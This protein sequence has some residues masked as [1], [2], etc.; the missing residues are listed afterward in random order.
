MLAALLV[1]VGAGFV[2]HRLYRFGL[3]HRAAA[4]GKAVWIK[5]HS[6][7]T[8][9]KNQV[10]QL[11]RRSYF[12]MSF[13]HHT[14]TPLMWA[15]H[16]GRRSAAS[17][18][19]DA[20]AAVDQ[21]DSLGRTALWIACEQRRPE[22]VQLLLERGAAPSVQDWRG[23][24]LLWVVIESMN[25]N[26]APSMD[27]LSQLLRAGAD[28]NDAGAADAPPL[29]AAV[30]NDLAEAVRL[31]LRYGAK[32]N[33]L[34]LEGRPLAELLP[35]PVE[36]IPAAQ[37]TSDVVAVSTSG[38]TELRAE[39]GAASMVLTSINRSKGA[40]MH[41]LRSELRL[42]RCAVGD[43]G[44]IVMLGI[45]TPSRSS[46]I[47][48][49][50]SHPDRGMLIDE[51]WADPPHGTGSIVNCD[52]SRRFPAI[53]PET[54]SIVI[55]KSLRCRAQ[56]NQRVDSFVRR[57]SIE[58]GRLLSESELFDGAGGV[59]GRIV[60]SA[61][62][63]G[64]DLIQV[65]LWPKS[66]KKNENLCDPSTGMPMEFALI[67]DTGEVV[68]RDCIDMYGI[69]IPSEG[70]DEKGHCWMGVGERAFGYRSPKGV[71]SYFTFERSPDGTQITVRQVDSAPADF[72]WDIPDRITPELAKHLDF[73][74]E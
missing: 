68:W 31:L 9:F 43:D 40:A 52:G 45:E 37:L 3:L 13:P 47:H 73:P 51:V 4:D 66:N 67:R 54:G 20:G 63:P 74:D 38:R 24:P 42:Y 56:G 55:M 57:Y 58:D 25:D 23:R 30:G 21:V 48:I 8:W 7:E 60:S 29:L 15:A 35:P 64:S 12:Q 62:V 11:S 65:M 39:S 10:L 28:P 44:L 72:S 59:P 33:N 18:L 36:A 70:C 49:L 27:I 69:I 14:L 71:T 34:T 53:L 32:P 1:A 19:L 26:S 61:P 41:T 2:A 16:E 17:A 50:A 6:H 22:L 46:P 5:N